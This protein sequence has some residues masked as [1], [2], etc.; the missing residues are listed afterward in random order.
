MKFKQTTATLLL[1]LLAAWPSLAGQSAQRLISADLVE[2]QQSTRNFIT[3]S[4]AEKNTRGWAT[5]ADAAGTT[6]VN[7]TG[8]A[9]TVTLTRS[10]ASPLAG[11]ASFV[12]TKDAANRQ[13]EGAS[14]DFT[15]D[16]ADSTNTPQNMV[17]DFYYLTGGTFVSGAS[18]DVRIFIYDITNASLITPESFHIN[19]S[20]GR[21]QTTFMPVSTS[22]SYRL[23]L[24]VATT[25]ANAW[26]LKLD[27][28]SINKLPTTFNSGGISSRALLTT[29]NG[30]GST[31]TNIRRYSTSV[32]Q[33]T[34]FTC[35][36]SAT[37]GGSCTITEDG[38]YAVNRIDRN[39]GAASNFGITKNDDCTAGGF[40]SVALADQAAYTMAASNVA[41]NASNAGIPLVSGDIIR[42]CDDSGARTNDST[43]R[44]S[45]FELAKVR[46]EA[47]PASFI[48][49][50]C[51]TATVTTD[52]NFKVCTYTSG[53]STFDVLSGSGTVRS[54][55]VG[56]G[57]A[58]GYSSAAGG[59]GA[60]GAIDTS[61]GG[62]YGVGSYTVTVGAAGIAVPAT[63]LGT[64]GGNSVF[65]STGANIVATGGGGGGRFNINGA[66]GGSGGGGLAGGAGTGGQGNAGGSGGTGAGNNDEGGGGGGGAGAV[67][68]NG[69]NGGGG[70]GGAGGVGL[71][72]NIS[73]AAV[74]YACGGGGGR[75][76]GNAGAGGCASA[77][78]GGTSGSGSSATGNTGSG[79]GG[80]PVTGAG[81]GATGVVILRYQ[82]Q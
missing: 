30:F 39:T 2:G 6:P 22:S 12:L 71:S 51:G 21:I 79:G 53:S 31:N 82:F 61:P 78:A 41:V 56:G 59:G 8:G 65:D 27:R 23:I 55:V 14:Y 52:G 36:D 16:A 48:V 73:G 25:S 5:Y 62:T 45:R 66:A 63:G 4:G 1:S 9:P 28:I 37:L 69:S 70:V 19:G 18:S 32:V 77:G 43:A 15:L 80:G 33:G 29:G 11:A 17:I 74:T 34:A 50:T 10:A 76:D 42:A 68:A 64:S 47:L 72:S 54:L 60:G 75:F 35:T 44:T 67:G 49:A 26:T 24:H 46:D 20:A 40:N 7:G 58:G 57:A 81:S 13:G 38:L 3:N